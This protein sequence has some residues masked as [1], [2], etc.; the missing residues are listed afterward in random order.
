[1][2]LCEVILFSLLPVVCGGVFTLADD[3]LVSA[4]F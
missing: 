4:I 1:M 2:K 3:A